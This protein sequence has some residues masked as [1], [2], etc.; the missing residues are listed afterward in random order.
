MTGDDVTSFEGWR[1]CSRRDD[2]ATTL[3][4]DSI[5]H[6]RMRPG[7]FIDCYGVASPQD[8]RAAARIITAL[9]G[10]A[11][12]LVRLRGVITAPFGLMQ[13]GQKRQARWPLFRWKAR[14]G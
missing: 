3:P 8:P 5:L 12:A 6:T 4:L 1:L 10:W 13:N 14:P 11:Q 2:S 7:D 9:H